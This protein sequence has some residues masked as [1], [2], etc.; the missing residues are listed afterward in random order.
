MTEVC[1]LLIGWDRCMATVDLW[2]SLLAA[3]WSCVT[4]KCSLPK[5]GSLKFSSKCLGH[6]VVVVAV[7]EKC[8]LMYGLR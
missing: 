8:D 3:R 4:L 5:P 1:S 7:G 2:I 6:G